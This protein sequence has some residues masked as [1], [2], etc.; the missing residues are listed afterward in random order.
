MKKPQGFEAMNK[1]E[2][3]EVITS[4]S[5][6]FSDSVLSELFPQGSQSLCSDLEHGLCVL[7]TALRFGNDFTGHGTVES[8]LS[9][10]PHPYG[11]FLRRSAGPSV[12][13]GK[14]VGV[15]IRSSIVSSPWWLCCE[16]VAGLRGTLWWDGTERPY[17]FFKGYSEDGGLYECTLSLG[18]DYGGSIVPPCG[19]VLDVRLCLNVDLSVLPFIGYASWLSARDA[20]RGLLS[21]PTGEFAS[22]SERVSKIAGCPLFK[23]VLL[24]PCKV[25][26]VDYCA[27]SGLSVASG[28]GVYSDVVRRFGSLFRYPLVGLRCCTLQGKSR[29]RFI[30]WVQSTGASGVYYVNVGSTYGGSTPMDQWYAIRDKETAASAAGVGHRVLLS[31]LSCTDY[32]S[33]RQWVLGV[34]LRTRE[35]EVLSRVVA[36]IHGRVTEATVGGYIGQI[37]E[38]TCEGCSMSGFLENPVISRVRYDLSAEASCYPLAFW[39]EKFGIVQL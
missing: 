34:D 4:V 33:V 36:V 15:S 12:L 29:D 25:G 26:A 37:V 35:G 38:V 11:A 21:L 16:D 28:F 39:N 5:D 18:N 13:R 8:V 1:K 30:G 10:L 20:V 3:W 23:F 31:V 9:S 7:R 14:Q 27:G 24:Y 32:D 2:L 17:L 19:L 6:R 22:V